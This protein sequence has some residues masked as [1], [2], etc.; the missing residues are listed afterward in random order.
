M[1]EPISL[2]DVVEAGVAS[3]LARVELQIPAR[4]EAYDADGQTVRVAPLL[5]ELVDDGEGNESPASLPVVDFVPVEWPGA[6]G[7]RLTFPLAVG[8]TGLLCFAGRSLD[9]WKAAPNRIVTPADNRRHSMTDA[10]FRPGLRSPAAPWKGARTDAVTLGY[11]GTSGMQ[12]HITPGGIALGEPSPAYAVALAEKVLTELTAL[13]SALA[14]AVVVPMDGG[15]S[16]KATI[17]AALASWPAS[18]GSA[19]VKVKP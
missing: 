18:M 3:G 8:D 10:V 17:L 13:K 2:A 15:A 4:V 19:S 12:V 5:R 14:S 11:D 9:E 7:A 16:L 6:G 1:S